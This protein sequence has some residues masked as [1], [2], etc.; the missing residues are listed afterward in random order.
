MESNK[1]NLRPIKIYTG[2]G[3][4]K[5]GYF[6]K[7]FKKIGE[8]GEEYMWA[9]IELENGQVTEEGANSITFLDR[10]IQK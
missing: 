1:E 4:D 3:T 9:L 10:K 7:W 6:H 5:T 2:T 8:E